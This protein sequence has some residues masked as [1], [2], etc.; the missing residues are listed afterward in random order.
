MD[1]TIVTL[2]SE[3]EKFQ[4][5]TEGSPFGIS[6]IGQDGRYKYINPKFIEIFGYTLKDISTGREWFRKKHSDPEHRKQVI[7][8]WF[9]DLE[10]LEIGEFKP[11]THNV[12]C[13]DGSERVIQFGGV[14][15]VT[16]EQFVII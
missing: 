9:S 10:E 13:K 2:Q 4:I 3:K 14:T 11:R 6:L 5:L 16:G 8:T 7:S 12:T 1:L 15:M